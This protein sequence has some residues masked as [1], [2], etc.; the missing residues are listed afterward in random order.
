MPEPDVTVTEQLRLDAIHHLSAVRQVVAAATAAFAG[1]QHDRA[2]EGRAAA[3]TILDSLADIDGSIAGTLAGLHRPVLWV[4]VLA[5]MKA[6]KSSLVNA[7]AGTDVM[8]VH[9]SAMTVLPTRVRFPP[10][11]ADAGEL[12]KLTLSAADADLL[13]RAL[14]EI[15]DVDEEV[16]T[17]KLSEEVAAA[18]RLLGTDERYRLRPAYHGEEDVVTALKAL[19]HLVR[20]GIQ[21]AIDTDVL[22]D[23]TEPP[24]VTV[25]ADHL[26]LAELRSDDAGELCLVDT[27]GPNEAQL[28]PRLM[29]VLQDE[30]ERAHAVLVVLDYSHMNSTA[31][32]DIRKL[33]DEWAVLRG[34][35]SIYLVINRVDQRSLI[36]GQSLAPEPLAR[37]A[38]S[39]FGLPADARDRV[40]EVVAIRANLANGVYR[41][42]RIGR[43]L[44]PTAS[45][46]AHR[47]LRE[48]HGR[49]WERRL[50]GTTAEE[51]REWADVLWQE[52]NL[53]ALLTGVIGRLR[54]HAT[55]IVVRQSVREAG[56][57][58]GDVSAAL[59]QYL[60]AASLDAVELKRRVTGLT[61]A[62]GEASAVATS[63]REH[64]GRDALAD[65]LRRD[66]ERAA[67]LARAQSAATIAEWRRSAGSQVFS[68]LDR[69]AA[70]NQGEGRS[71]GAREG[72]FKRAFR[73][74]A[75]MIGYS[76]NG[77]TILPNGCYHF[78]TDKT[79]AEVF[80]RE[81]VAL[82]QDSARRL[83]D[84]VVDHADQV[85][86][87]TV[88]D[89]YRRVGERLEPLVL[90]ALKDAGEQDPPASDPPPRSRSLPRSAEPSLDGGSVT[91]VEETD[92]AEFLGVKLW[93]KK[94]VHDEYQ[95]FPADVIESVM[96]RFVT[97]LAA[98]A[99][100]RA[101]AA[102]RSHD[103]AVDAY[104]EQLQQRLRLP[105]GA[106]QA[107]QGE[108]AGDIEARR[109]ALQP[110]RDDAAACKRRLDQLLRRAESF[111]CGTR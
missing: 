5:I 23:L 100:V 30:V 95:V 3:S 38:M 26:P 111:T 2:T 104:A 51:I 33:V 60:A 48:W 85:Y 37:K 88:D 15:H 91:V 11:G 108:L 56:I 52:S 109:Q 31:D 55:P 71:S 82:V 90:A 70:A 50:A 20:A 24:T 9:D 57:R 1:P 63:C 36:E 7:I 8:P 78:G 93:R 25:A 19:N 79:N 72:M 66:A 45:P 17:A 46:A 16:R 103:G 32:A 99:D 58:A 105:L 92:R 61:E 28:A 27:A 73:S 43:D 87:R 97:Q 41:D 98:A 76:V 62:I 96:R 34:A 13:R 54:A 110:V 44:R 14:D 107:A 106:L 83:H 94:T 59:D 29:K 80:L 77:A 47:V 86:R 49:S 10:V 81:V 67:E 22:G 101:Q 53:P 21:L 64:P 84:D 75:N 69:A 74:V 6:G 89:G 39:V 18:V 40:F 65:E 12:P 102:A 4:P 42:E 68:H 35:Q